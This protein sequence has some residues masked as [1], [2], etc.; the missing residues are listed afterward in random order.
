MDTPVTGTPRALLRLEA[1]AILIASVL[2]YGILGDSWWEF[3][4]LVLVPDLAIVAYAGGPRIG[5]MLYNAMHTYIGPVAAGALAFA[6]V[7]PERAGPICLVWVAHIA[8]DRALGLGL[9]FPSA[10][11]ATHLGRIGRVAATD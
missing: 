7:L 9:K 3:A 10:F 8:M 11:Q 2:A 5:A 4:L 6:E 1:M